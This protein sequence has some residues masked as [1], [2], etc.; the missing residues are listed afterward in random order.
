MFTKLEYIFFETWNDIYLTYI[1]P[2]WSSMILYVS[3]A[4]SSHIVIEQY[5]SSN[6]C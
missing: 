6:F 3:N 5:I 2:Y 1:V 4:D